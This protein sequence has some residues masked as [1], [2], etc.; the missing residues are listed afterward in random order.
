MSGSVGIVNA[1]GVAVG[2][3]DTDGAADDDVIG[4][5][6]VAGAH[7]TATSRV[8]AATLFHIRRWSTTALERSSHLP[9]T[10]S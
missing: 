10:N 2:D 1:P 6:P 7:E 8:S 3:A 5:V 9:A 4:G